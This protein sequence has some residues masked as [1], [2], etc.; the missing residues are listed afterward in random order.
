MTFEKTAIRWEYHGDTSLTAGKL[1]SGFVAFPFEKVDERYVL[2]RGGQGMTHLPYLVQG[3]GD[4]GLLQGVNTIEEGIQ[5]ATEDLKVKRENQ[6]R[7]TA[8]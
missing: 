2:W 7:R 6:T 3:L 1:V 5:L 4:C 8:K